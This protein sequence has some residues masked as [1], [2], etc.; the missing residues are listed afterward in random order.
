MGSKIKPTKG[1]GKGAGTPIPN[2]FI[3][4]IFDPMGLLVGQAMGYA[5]ALATGTPPTGPVLINNKPAA[6]VGT[7]AK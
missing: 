4:L 6:N 5:M 2:P 7:E 3:G 1:L